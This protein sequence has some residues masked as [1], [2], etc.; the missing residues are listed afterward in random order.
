MLHVQVQIHYYLMKRCAFCLLGRTQ[1]TFK[2]D[3]F[4]Y[5]YNTAIF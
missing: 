2:L 5:T 3:N 4:Q 1:T